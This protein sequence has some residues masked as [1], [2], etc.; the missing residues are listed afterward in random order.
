M[1]ENAILIA[2]EDLEDD[3]L[4][5]NHMLEKVK[6]LENETEIEIANKIIERRKKAIEQDKKVLQH[7]IDENT[8]ETR[9]IKKLG[10][11]TEGTSKHEELMTIRLKM[12]NVDTPDFQRVEFA[13]V[14]NGY[15]KVHMF[16][17]NGKESAFVKLTSKGIDLYNIVK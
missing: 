10:K 13:L 6:T 2:K 7:L 5:L 3:V 14:D 4:F 1:N 15:I 8:N 17:V 12:M 16:T 9:F 11:L